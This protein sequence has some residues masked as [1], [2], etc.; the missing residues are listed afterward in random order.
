MCL[1]LERSG[2]PQQSTGFTLVEIAI[3]MVIVS[4]VFAGGLAGFRGFRDGATYSQTDNYLKES[5]IALLGFALS[6]GYLPCPDTDDDGEQ[7][8]ELLTSGKTC[9]ASSG[10]LPWQD[11]GLNATPPWSAPI[12]YAINAQATTVICNDADKSVC[13]FE[14]EQSPAFDLKTPPRAGTAG[15]GNLVVEGSS[16]EVIADHVIA[17]L[18]SGG[19]NARQTAADCAAVSADESENCDGDTDFVM[20]ITRTNEAD[21]F[22]DQLI[23]IHANTLKGQMRDAGIL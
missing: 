9:T 10:A 17:V 18:V 1:S 14:D 21:F 19:K 2:S 16:G 7:N 12:T 13:F 3:V 6:Q 15:D 8:T 11:L 20:D 5:Q 4:L 22:D 23:W